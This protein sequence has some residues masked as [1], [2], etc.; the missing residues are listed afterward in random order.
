MKKGI[1]IFGGIIIACVATFFLYQSKESKSNT[2]LKQTEPKKTEQKQ[3]EQKTV[4][5]VEKLDTTTVAK[6]LIPNAKEILLK[7]GE[8]M[9]VALSL[10]L[11]DEETK[12][13]NTFN[14]GADETEFLSVKSKSEDVAE[15]KIIN[16]G[17]VQI[18]ANDSP[19]QTS[20]EIEVTY[21][22]K[23][24]NRELEVKIPI[25]IKD[26][27]SSVTQ[28]LE[29]YWR[30]E[31][32]KKL[33]VKINKQNTK[34]IEFQ[35]FDLFEIWYTGDVQFHA[36][37]QNKLSG[38]MKYSQAYAQDGDLPSDESFT[39]DKVS[40]SKIIV[41]KGKDILNLKKSSKKEFE[42][43]QQTQLPVTEASGTSQNDKTGEKSDG[44]TD[45]SSVDAKEV[46]IEFEV[47][48]ETNEIITYFPKEKLLQVKK[49]Q[50]IKLHHK[51]MDPEQSIRILVS[52]DVLNIDVVPHEGRVAAP[53]EE[54]TVHPVQKGN[55][56]I[57]ILPNLDME[58]AYT[59]G[60]EV[61]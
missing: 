21:R 51:N 23:K 15:A 32:N 28:G 18:T 25:T 12:K 58:K 13:E 60:V 38:R 33:F 20:T 24:K 14:L 53:A 35:A 11:Y 50:T 37:K 45:V 27:E 7:P 44:G 61:K 29:G 36:S 52:G 6:E 43:E 22:N 30:D 59:I 54:H 41:H 10:K 40:A 26:Q 46:Y 56:T 31:N 34:N 17:Q 9:N 42:Q 48:K 4:V 55:G 3:D 19:S 8:E 39:L 49:G 2:E 57:K 5:N 16:S 47:K 1:I